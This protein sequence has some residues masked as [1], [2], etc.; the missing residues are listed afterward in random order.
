MPS[1]KPY[2]AGDPATACSVKKVVSGSTP[3]GAYSP[4]VIA[5]GRFLY[6]SGQG[7][8]RNGKVVRGSIEQ[9]VALTLENLAGVVGSAG[10]GLDD[11]VQCRVFLADIA[12]F[13]AMDA[14]YG[15]FMPD[16]KPAR[17]TIGATLADGIKVEIDAVVV[18]P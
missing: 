18:M 16:P 10:A 11:I 7:P 4:G 9:E 17:T 12:D 13:A 14:V 6:I 5:E 3:T 15:A 1:S 2:Q 8:L